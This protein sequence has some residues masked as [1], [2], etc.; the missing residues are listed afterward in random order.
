MGTV[1]NVWHVK[2]LARI[3]QKMIYKII[4]EYIQDNIPGCSFVGIDG[5]YF[6]EY[7]FRVFN[8]SVAIKSVTFHKLFRDIRRG[9]KPMINLFPAPVRKKFKTAGRSIEGAYYFLNK[10]NDDFTD[11]H[12]AA[13]EISALHEFYKNEKSNIKELVGEIPPWPMNSV[14]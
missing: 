4:A 6:D 7:K 13:P 2:P 8:K 11:S 10:S 3:K 9:A 12:K 1:S 14:E 5:E